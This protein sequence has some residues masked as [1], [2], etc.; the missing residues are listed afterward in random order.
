ML[1][2]VYLREKVVNL[3]V[4]PVGTLIPLKIL[5]IGANSAG[6]QAIALA[7]RLGAIVDVFD[8]IEASTL[9]KKSLG[10]DFIED[11]SDITK[12]DIVLCTLNISSQNTNIILT[13]KMVVSMKPGSVIGDFV[14][15]EGGNCILTQKDQLIHY[16][17]VKIIGYSNIIHRL[18][19]DAS[20]LYAESLLNF[21]LLI[22][23]TYT[24]EIEINLA[25]EIIKNALLTYNGQIVNKNLKHKYYE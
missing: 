19:Y 10:V 1:E 23:N 3:M 25:D 22:Y 16:S 20:K 14:G 5:V 17:G 2:A 8:T 18:A 7:K 21:I 9:V 15:K 11:I 24:K 13:E 6:M 12:Y 4:T